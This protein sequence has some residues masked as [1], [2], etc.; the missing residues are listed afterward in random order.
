MIRYPVPR[1]VI[2]PTHYGTIFTASYNLIWSKEIV[3]FGTFPKDHRQTITNLKKR[4]VIPILNFNLGACILKRGNTAQIRNSKFITRQNK[5]YSDV[6]RACN[7]QLLQMIV[8]PIIGWHVIDH[9]AKV[10]IRFDCGSML[11]LISN[12]RLRRLGVK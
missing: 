11:V 12:S 2:S 6:D 7:I 8:I 10:S 4:N 9:D 1:R 3:A 5:P